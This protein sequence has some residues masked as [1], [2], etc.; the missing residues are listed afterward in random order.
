MTRSRTTITSRTKTFNNTN[1]CSVPSAIHLR[2]GGNNNQFRIQG[3]LSI[4]M[5]SSSSSSSVSTSPHPMKSPY[6]SFRDGSILSSAALDSG[7][8]PT[9]KESLSSRPASACPGNRLYNYV[10]MLLLGRNHLGLI[11][12]SSLVSC[13]RR[14]TEG[15]VVVVVLS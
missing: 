2:F 13:R 6:S 15:V 11:P 3:P 8:I 9:T 5:C 1:G 7:L 12:Y 10:G 4:E 14:G